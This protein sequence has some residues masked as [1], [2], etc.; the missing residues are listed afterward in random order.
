MTFGASPMPNHRISQGVSAYF[1]MPCEARMNGST[2]E[3]ARGDSRSTNG[4]PMP[5]MQPMTKPSADTRSVATVSVESLPLPVI[6]T[7]RSAVASGGAKNSGPKRARRPLPGAEQ[8]QREHDAAAGDDPLARDGGGF[9]QA[10]CDVG[11]AHCTSAR[12]RS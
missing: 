2:A 1:G 7:I 4:R 8:R 10:G 11:A 5:M 6:S 12:I 3:V 9:R